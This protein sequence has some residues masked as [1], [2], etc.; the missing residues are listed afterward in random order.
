[1]ANDQQTEGKLEQARG[2]LKEG[3]G[4][5]IGNERMRDE[6]KLDQGKGQIR[7]GVGNVREDVDRAADDWNANH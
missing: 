6:G 3:V 5:A 1:M 4:D 2:T 7:E